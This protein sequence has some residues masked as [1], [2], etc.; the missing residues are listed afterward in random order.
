M[1]DDLLV[2][3]PT[4]QEER[5]RHLYACANDIVERL[6]S[7]R[8][9]FDRLER[10]EIMV[11]GVEKSPGLIE[12]VEALTVAILQLEVVL[13]RQYVE[14]SVF[15]RS[16]EVDIKD[17]IQAMDDALRLCADKVE[18]LLSDRR[19]SGVLYKMSVGLGFV[20]FI[21]ILAVGGLQLFA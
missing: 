17:R 21:F 2:R 12:C 14:S 5:I 6:E 15:M 4:R 13:S 19:R 18:V 9:A 8:G 1:N 10:V 20:M 11:N 16:S 7:I 3:P